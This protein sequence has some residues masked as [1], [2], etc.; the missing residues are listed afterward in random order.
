MGYILPAGISCSLTL[1]RKSRMV[2]SWFSSSAEPEVAAPETQRGG[3]ECVPY[4]VLESHENYQ[5]RSYPQSK[6]ATVLYEKPAAGPGNND[7]PMSRGWNQQPQN[8]SFRKLFRYITGE[9]EG[10]AKISMTVPVSTKVTTEQQGEESVVREE[11]GFY[12]PCEHQDVTPQPAANT[13]VKIVTRAEMVAFVREFS[14]YAKEQHWQDEKELLKKDLQSRDDFQQ[15]DFDVFYRQGFD[16]P[17]K[18]WGRKN[19]VFF[20]KKNTE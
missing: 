2:F 3:Y 1:R 11:M 9:N 18:F 16:A 7:L 15:I 12:V 4:T 5:V 6:W 17:Y 10:G 14:G 8:T 19:E 20:V 13:D